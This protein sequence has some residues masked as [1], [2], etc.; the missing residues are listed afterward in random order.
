[1]IRVVPMVL[2]ILADPQVQVVLLDHWRLCLLVV[3]LVQVRHSTLNHQPVPC[4]L[5]VPADQVIPKNRDHLLDLEYQWHRYHPLLQA[6]LAHLDSQQVHCYQL[7]LGVR[8]ILYLPLDLASPEHQHHLWIQ[9]PL[10]RRLRRGALTGLVV[11]EA[12]RGLVGLW[13]LGLRWVQPGR[14]VPVIPVVL[15][16]L[17]H[18]TVLAG[19]QG[20]L[21]PAPGHLCCLWLPADP[22]DQAVPAHRSCPSLQ[23]FLCFLCPRSY[24]YLQER[25]GPRWGLWVH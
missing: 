23:E 9:W 24:R 18:Q 2:E 17:C 14:F 25:P 10:G 3:Q 7:N 12:P 19:Q 21:L 1:M 6:D 16:V 22:E 8:M 5:V 15:V 4:R 13:R 11:Q 20:R